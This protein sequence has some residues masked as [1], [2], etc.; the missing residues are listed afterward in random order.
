MNLKGKAIGITLIAGF[1][2]ALYGTKWLLFQELHNPESALPNSQREFLENLINQS[3]LIIL[4][5]IVTFSIA[6]YYLQ[7]FFFIP[8][9]LEI[10]NVLT[11]ADQGN[12][13]VRAQG[14]SA[15]SKLVNSILDKLSILVRNIDQNTVKIEQSA[16][17][18]SSLA[19]E[20]SAANSQEQHRSADVY[21]CTEELLSIST[22]IGELSDTTRSNAASSE[23]NAKQSLDIVTTNI[24]NMEGTVTEV[25]NASEQMK[26]LIDATKGIN[27]IIETIKNI[28]EQTNL[29]A[30]NAAIEAAR[31]GDQ[32]RGFAVVA[33]EVRTLANRTTKST[34]EIS[35]ILGKLTKRADLANKTMTSVVDKVYTSRN[36]AE[37]IKDNITTVVENISETVLSNTK[38]HQVSSQQTDMFNKLRE[39]I[40]SYLETISKSS[41]KVKTTESIVCDIHKIKESMNDLITNYEYE[42]EIFDDVPDDIKEKRKAQRITHPMR[43]V[44]EHNGESLDCVSNDLS[45]SGMQLRLQKPIDQGKEIQLKIYLP[46]NNPEQYNKQ[47]PLL[48]TGIIR[49]IGED[50]DPYLSG[51]EF[52]NIGHTHQIWFD[53]CFNFFDK[54]SKSQSSNRDNFETVEDD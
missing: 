51:I 33:D 37:V 7:K 26:S 31:A 48:V 22:T 2:S 38:I 9:N 23:E 5:I 36:N 49:W 43:V 41:N 27:E 44:I 10:K 29:L 50:D 24:R 45:S 14:A 52:I 25:N 42:N 15:L 20:I 4:G 53:Q 11:T 21:S 54:S 3:S 30:L 32:G 35:Q 8:Q 13:E 34:E 16:I 47:K 40:N 1:I 6:F 46:Y 12:I 18:V 28:A 19:Q 39:Q 17:Q